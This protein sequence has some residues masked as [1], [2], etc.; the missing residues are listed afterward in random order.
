MDAVDQCLC[1]ACLTYYGSYLCIFCWFRPDKVD[2]VYE[3]LP[4]G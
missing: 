2:N 4:S 3:P 1:C